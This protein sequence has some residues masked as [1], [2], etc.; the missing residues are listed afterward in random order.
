MP[1]NIICVACGRFVALA[2]M[3]DGS[4]V[5]HFEPDSHKGPEV[6][7]WTCAACVAKD[8]ATTI[9]TAVP[10]ADLAVP[11]YGPSGRPGYQTGRKAQNAPAGFSMGTDKG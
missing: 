4:A 3:Q 8:R 11:A 10:R 1:T 6:S 7:E 2:E 9:S 5:F